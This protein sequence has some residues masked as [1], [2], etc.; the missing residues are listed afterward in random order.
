VT[1]ECRR[2]RDRGY[3]N[4]ERMYHGDRS[5]FWTEACPDCKRVYVH[6]ALGILHRMATTQDEIDDNMGQPLVCPV[7]GAPCLTEQDEFCDDYGCARRAGIDVDRDLIAR[8]AGG[9]Q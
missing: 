3:I 4:C 5:D 8:S 6:R 1:F 9:A 7:T 2:C